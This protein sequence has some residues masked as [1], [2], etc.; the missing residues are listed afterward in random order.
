MTG[1]NGTNFD[2]LQ[3]PANQ[4]T[5]YPLELRWELTRRHPY[6]LALWRDVRDYHKNPLA[7]EEPERQAYLMAKVALGQIGVTGIPIAPETPFADIAGDDP[8]FLCGSV[9]P[10]TIRSIAALLL[11]L[12]NANLLRFLGDAFHR[13]ADIV[14]D[15]STE[16]D[17]RS[18]QRIGLLT[19][20]RLAAHA[21]L[22]SVAD[23]PLLLMNAAASLE[24]IKADIGHQAKIWKAKRSL[25]SPKIHF[26]KIPEY[27]TIWDAI[28]GWTGQGY[29]LNREQVFSKVATNTGRSVSAIHAQYKSAFEHII[30]RE[31]I[32]SRWWQVMGRFK[33]N[34]TAGTSSI[35][36][37]RQLR[38]MQEEIIKKTPV[39]PE[40]VVSQHAPIGSLG[41]VQMAG[42]CNNDLE[43]LDLADRLTEYIQK[44]ATDATI[45][46]ALGWTDQPKMLRLI[47]Y[48]RDKKI[49]LGK[50]MR[51]RD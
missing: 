33:I 40:S 4:L 31:F 50:L 41:V 19:A 49:D 6:Y 45:V 2:F 51:E 36:L 28:E 14:G 16:D 47:Q 21:E 23:I 10:M 39:V 24:T 9:Q 32:P 44:G 17:I 22:D 8:A 15:S 30:G 12:Q 20:I 46:E 5:N 35:A 11:N 13:C 34:T 18:A 3:R 1:E 25:E 38:R 43:A 42:A 37:K 27:L 7:Q 48:A 26:G 29:D